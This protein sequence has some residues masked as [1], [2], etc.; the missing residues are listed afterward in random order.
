[1]HTNKCEIYLLSVKIQKKLTGKNI[2]F[3]KLYKNKILVMKFTIIIYQLINI[4][5]I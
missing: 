2:N 1:M 3:K 5:N 4:K